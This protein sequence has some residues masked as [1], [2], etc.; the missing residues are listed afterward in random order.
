MYLFE[1][2]Y[3]STIYFFI[4]ISQRHT[5]T[6]IEFPSYLLIAIKS[7]KNNTHQMGRI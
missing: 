7:M 3:E 6:Y 4:A 5:A 2:I 1:L